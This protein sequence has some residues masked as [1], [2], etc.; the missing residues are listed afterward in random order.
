MY[1]EEQERFEDYLELERYIEQLRSQRSVSPPANLTPQLTPI[2]EM[3]R[4]FQAACCARGHIR[5]RE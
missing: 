2:Y 1:E 5:P 4:I 3:A